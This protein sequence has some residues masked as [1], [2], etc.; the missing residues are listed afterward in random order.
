MLRLQ[1]LI[2][3]GV[4]THSNYMGGVITQR[5][6][7]PR[8]KPV[9]P[10]RKH[11]KKKSKKGLA[12]KI[13]EIIDKGI[14]D[15]FSRKP[16]GFQKPR[17]QVEDPFYAQLVG[18]DIQD[19]LGSPT[20]RK[21]FLD[22]HTSPPKQEQQR[23]RFERVKQ[24]IAEGQHSKDNIEEQLSGRKKRTRFELA[25]EE[26][27]IPRLREQEEERRPLNIEG[28]DRRRGRCFFI[29]PATRRAGG[30]QEIQHDRGHRRKTA[31]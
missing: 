13:A 19:E 21:R 22:R 2:D 17:V 4:L 3:Q 20:G 25:E 24:T 7:I 28:G 18:K 27:L 16:H 15:P 30:R 8:R 23:R 10:G 12:K 1:D 26:K 14:S 29:G 9:S 5:R 31:A 11:K 6:R